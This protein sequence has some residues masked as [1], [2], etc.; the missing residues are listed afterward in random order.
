[1]VDHDQVDD[2]T[3]LLR[4]IC[5]LTLLSALIILLRNI[6]VQLQQQLTRLDEKTASIVVNNRSINSWNVINTN[7]QTN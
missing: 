1:M 4:L 2:Q 6:N 3:V 7:K 5:L